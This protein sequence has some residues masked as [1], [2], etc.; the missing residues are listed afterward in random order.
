GPRPVPRPLPT[1]ALPVYAS[2][3]SALQA[4]AALE[5]EGKDIRAIYAHAADSGLKLLANQAW[6]VRNG[7]G[8]LNAFLLKEQAQSYAKANGGEALD[9][10][11]VNQKLLAQR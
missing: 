8:E 10:V 4:L 2:P 3:E 5:E 11:S 6:F 7:Q 9:F 1:H